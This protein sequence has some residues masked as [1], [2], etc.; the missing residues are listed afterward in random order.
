M[1]CQDRLFMFK[2]LDQEFF[3]FFFWFFDKDL[4]RGLIVAETCYYVN[5]EK[6][7]KKRGG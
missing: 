2:D 5:N 1:G 6:V 3:F 7:V 4:D